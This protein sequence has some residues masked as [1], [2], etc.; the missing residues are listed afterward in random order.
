LKIEKCKLE[1]TQ[2]AGCA[3]LD[4]PNSIC[5]FQFRYIKSE[6]LGWLGGARRL[7][8]TARKFQ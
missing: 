5:N 2:E 6:W 3:M 7:V 4:E 1:I 8:E